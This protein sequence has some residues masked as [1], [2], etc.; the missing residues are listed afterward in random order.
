MKSEKGYATFNSNEF[1]TKIN[2]SILTAPYNPERKMY[3][4]R[5][6]AKESFKL[7]RALS[8]DELETFVIKK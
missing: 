1:G 2:G 8:E 4:V 5:D 6:M 3:K 7:G